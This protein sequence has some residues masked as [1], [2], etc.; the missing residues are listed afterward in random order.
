MKKNFPNWVEKI[1][2]SVLC[3][4]RQFRLDFTEFLT[5]MRCFMNSRTSVVASLPI[6]RCFT[7]FL[8]NV[9]SLPSYPTLLHLLSNVAS[10]L[11]YPMLLHFLSN[12]ASFT[13]LLSVLLHLLLS[14]A[15]CF[16]RNLKCHL[17]RTSAIR[18]VA[19]S[20]IQP[21]LHCRFWC[22]CDARES[23]E[24]LVLPLSCSTSTEM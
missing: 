23:K 16:L 2:A 11:S 12:V 19:V 8:S 20:F 21:D 1:Y 22:S 7:S 13:P 14:P 6:Q 9:A 15:F 24:S 3:L 17:N 5:L 4:L 18:P 10:L